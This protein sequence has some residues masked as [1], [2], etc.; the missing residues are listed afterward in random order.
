LRG[1]RAE[2]RQAFREALPALDADTLRATVREHLAPALA[3]APT[4][5]LAGRERLETARAEGV[6]LAISD[7]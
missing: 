5:V 4:C 6:D 1:S 7:L 2:Q 3:T